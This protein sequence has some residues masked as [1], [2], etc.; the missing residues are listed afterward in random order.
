[1]LGNFACFFMSAAD[2]FLNHFF[3]KRNFRNTIRVPNSLDPDQTQHFVGPDPD[4]N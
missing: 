3:F 1:M 4:A 2:F